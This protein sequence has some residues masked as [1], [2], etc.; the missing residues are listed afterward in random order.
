MIIDTHVHVFS[1]DRKK[2]P[3]IADTA[4]AGTIPS[5]TDIGQQPWPATDGDILVKEMDK[6][7]I[8]KAT[9]VQAYFVYEYDNSYACDVAAKYPD[10][11]VTV[12]A[13]DPTDP[14]APDKL[15]D[16]VEN[17]GVKGIRFM[18]GRL[19]ECTL[20]NKE[21]EGLWA[22]IEKLKIPLCIHDQVQELPRV[23]PFL[24]KY[25]DITVAFDH[26][27]GHK[28]GSPP[29]DLIRPLFDMS[30]YPNVTVKTAINN[31]AAAKKE[32][33]STVE[34]FYTKLVDTFGADRIMWSSNY[35]A[36]PNFGSMESRLK[37]AREELAFLGQD[38]LDWILG[39][40]AARVWPWLAKK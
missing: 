3:Q 30:V 23:R 6:A 27:W 21:T 26:G 25:S 33:D 34:K 40:T 35:P 22:R 18:R 16:L 38:A 5:I 28:V 14:G 31:I 1:G 11:F 7:G 9:L 32:A 2:Y 17:H 4:K 15:T 37:V 19:P 10:R 12:C 8:D 13:L 24:E 39:N 20:G 29:Y 36:H